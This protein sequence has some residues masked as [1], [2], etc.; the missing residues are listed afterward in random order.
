MKKPHATEKQQ[1]FSLFWTS[2]IPF[3]TVML[4]LAFLPLITLKNK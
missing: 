1:A 3:G 2:F 4:L